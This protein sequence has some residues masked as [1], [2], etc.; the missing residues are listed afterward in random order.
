MG[1]LVELYHRLPYPL[2]VVA[3]SAHGYK[4]RQQR[5]TPHTEDLAAAALERET[6]SAERWQRWQQERLAALLQR[7]ATQVPYYRDYWQQRR[8]QGDH[9]AWDVLDN[10]PILTKDTLR[11]Q[12][13]AFV[14]DDC[15]MRRL[16]R[17]STSGTTGKPLSIWASRDA[18]REWFGLFEAR[19]RIWNGVSRA[20]AWAMFGGQ[21]VAPAAQTRPPFW[22]WNAGLHQLYLSSYHVA[23]ARVAAYL[24]AMRRHDVQYMLGYSHAMYSLAQAVLEAGEEAPRL[25][26]AISNAEPLYDEQRAAIQAAFGCPTRKTYGMVE[27]VAAASECG[28]GTLHVWPEV[29]LIQVRADEEDM[30]LAAGQTGRLICTG[31]L[32]SDMPLI[33]YE[34]GDRGAMRPDSERCACGRTLPALYD[35][36]G[37]LGD[38]IV[39]YDGRRIGRLGTAIKGDTAVREVQIIQ[40]TLDQLRVRF[41][42]APGYR[43]EDGVL[44]AQRLRERVG[45]MDVV[46]EPVEHI[47]RTSNG[48]FRAVIS[49]VAQNGQ[50]TPASEAA[51]QE[52]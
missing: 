1:K 7:A 52:R 16:H 42:P 47:P 28:Q 43:P 37:R 34:V 35:V 45:E 39:T 33:R 40:E 14:A 10:W 26:V 19:L 15:D 11:E 29:G 23:P 2:R 25:R 30:P 49:H 48:K 46:L 51:S 41:V 38:V 5:Y 13:H 3:A 12:P 18:I 50:H 44:L 17:E 6:W 22:V 20:D 32:N 24:A 21:L 8:R 36:E 4:L 31:L 27:M 9:A